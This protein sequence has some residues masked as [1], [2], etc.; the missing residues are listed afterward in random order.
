ME[1]HPKIPR[2]RLLIYNFTAL[3]VLYVFV[4]AIVHLLIG[5]TTPNYLGYVFVIFPIHIIFCLV[6]LFGCLTATPGRTFVHYIPAQLGQV[7]IA[8]GL[9]LFL[10]PAQCTK[11][12][13][14]DRCHALIQT[15]TSN[16]QNIPSDRL[17]EVAFPIALVTYLVLTIWFFK[18]TQIKRIRPS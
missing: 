4:S 18:H 16:T 13:Q 5:N 14:G 6:F 8:Q 3:W 10:T 11:W 15:L 9:L 1:N 12:K 2:D 17:L 7:F